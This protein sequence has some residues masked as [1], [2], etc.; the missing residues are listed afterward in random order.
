MAF[1]FHEI[2][3]TISA[4][5]SSGSCSAYRLGRTLM[6]KVIHASVIGTSHLD[7]GTSCQDKSVVDVYD[8]RN[9]DLQLICMVADGAGSAAQGGTGAQLACTAGSIFLKAVLRD[10]QPLN[11]DLIIDMVAHI[12][13]E[14]FQ[15]A[16]D[17]SRPVRDF[18][19]TFIG[20]V[21]T[22]SISVFFQIGDGA[23]VVSKKRCYG[24]VFWPDSGQYVNMTH[25]ITDDD[26]LKHLHIEITTTAF[27]DL[28]IISDGL[29]NLALDFKYK[30]PHVPFFLPM[31]DTLRKTPWEQVDHI[32]AK[33]RQ[34][35]EGK[36]VNER[37]DD[38]KT[39]IL[40][41]KV[42]K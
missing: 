8:D 25:F 14:I 10:G 27:D 32:R 34:Y 35:L 9:G 11:A 28:A 33:L 12:R 36:D 31:L 26:A 7:S 4:R 15:K 38:D 30:I 19:S 23:I 18:A 39:L 37:T 41:A 22:K 3:F 29:Q 16:R 6:W 42:V 20:A 40:A 21:F 2:C 5:R 17:S 13:S 24:I 1:Q